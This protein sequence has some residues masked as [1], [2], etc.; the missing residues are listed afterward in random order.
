M[1]AKTMR[2]TTVP[3]VV[4]SVRTVT[5]TTDVRSNRSNSLLLRTVRRLRP[6]TKREGQATAKA[7][8]MDN[9]PIRTAIRTATATTAATAT[10]SGGRMVATA[11]AMREKTTNRLTM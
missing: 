4:T 2:K 10:T 9:R 7:R 8:T 1:V 3:S 6:V 5:A 11:E